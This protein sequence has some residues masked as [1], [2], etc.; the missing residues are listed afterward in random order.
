MLAAGLIPERTADP[1]R[2]F[3]LWSSDGAVILTGNRIGAGA[4]LA[5]ARDVFGPRLFVCHSPSIV[6][7]STVRD[8]P[9]GCG[10]LT[11][12]A[13]GHAGI[14]AQPHIDGWLEFRDYYPDVV[15]VLGQRQAMRGGQWFVVDGQRLLDGLASDPIRR[16]LIRFLWDVKLG[17]GQPSDSGM[18]GTGQRAATCRPAAS[19]TCGGRLTIRCHPYQRLLEDVAPPGHADRHHLAAWARITEQAARVA[20]RFALG[21]GE[22]LCL[23]NYRIFHGLQPCAEV[24]TLGHTLWAWTDMAFGLPYPD[25]LGAQTAGRTTSPSHLLS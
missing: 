11:Q 5:G 13:I 19:R 22:L 14:D 23:D 1:R 16:A 18:V 10:L 12:A 2:A 20:P 21:P 9:A 3:H 24:A 15:F 17:Q 25:D 4:T 8:R 6:A 7:A